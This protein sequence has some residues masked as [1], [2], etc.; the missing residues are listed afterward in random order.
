MPHDVVIEG[1][2]V[3]AG[4]PDVQVSEQRGTDVAG[5]PGVDQVGGEYPAEVVGGKRRP[6]EEVAQMG[7]VEE[8]RHGSRDPGMVLGTS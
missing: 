3:S 4:G 2:D 6:D 7:G 1:R 8:P 5:Q